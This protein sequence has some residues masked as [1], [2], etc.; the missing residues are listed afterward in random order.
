MHS[1][2]PR[3]LKACQLTDISV[4]VETDGCIQLTHDLATSFPEAKIS[5]PAVWITHEV[6]RKND[7]ISFKNSA[8]TSQEGREYEDNTIG[9]H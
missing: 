1:I 3:A 6:M 9:N 7:L 5:R 2:I 4:W 8:Q